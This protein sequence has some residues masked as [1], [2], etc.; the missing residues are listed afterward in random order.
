ME[1]SEW[2]VPGIMRDEC[3]GEK[4]WEESEDKKKPMLI[5]KILY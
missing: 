1:E 3:G 5:S 2:R 4:K